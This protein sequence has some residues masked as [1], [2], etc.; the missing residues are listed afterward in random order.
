VV[1][2]T[3]GLMAVTS[4][5]LD[6]EVIDGYKAEGEGIVILISVFGIPPSMIA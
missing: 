5:K 6:K 3:D 4:V 1:V 2:D